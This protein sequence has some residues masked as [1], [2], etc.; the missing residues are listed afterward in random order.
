MVG[1]KV[2]DIDI[3]LLI[4]YT[5]L[6][7]WNVHAESTRPNGGYYESLFKNYCNNVIDDGFCCLLSGR[8]NH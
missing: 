1:D 2:R 6:S 5:D 4:C 8:A 7:K 3:F